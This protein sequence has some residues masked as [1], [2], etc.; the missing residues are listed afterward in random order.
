[1]RRLLLLFQVRGLLARGLQQVFRAVQLVH[2]A[3]GGIVALER[4]QVFAVASLVGGARFP[5]SA[6]ILD[7]AIQIGQRRL[8]IDHR[9]QLF[10]RIGNAL[11]QIEQISV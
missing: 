6:W 3:L 4:G 5:P 1:M 11:D 9:L 7:A 2:K 8:R 10:Q